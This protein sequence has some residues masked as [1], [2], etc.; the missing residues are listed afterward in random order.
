M[1]CDASEVVNTT[2]GVSCVYKRFGGD[3]LKG[4]DVIIDK[5]QEIKNDYNVIAGYRVEASILK[6]QIPTVR[7]GDEFTGD[8]ET[9]KVTGLTKETTSKWYVDIVKVA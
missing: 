4:V 7:V 9:W 2:L 8:D 6:S 5:N 3:R 1:M